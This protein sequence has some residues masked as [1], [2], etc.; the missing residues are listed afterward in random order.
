MNFCSREETF[1]S[2]GSRR[3]AENMHFAFVLDS[4]FY[5]LFSLVLKCVS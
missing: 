3:C 5:G 2:T 1:Q 4:I